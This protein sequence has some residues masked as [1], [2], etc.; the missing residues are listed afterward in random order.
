MRKLLLKWLD[1]L[2]KHLENKPDKTDYTKLMDEI[3]RE[4]TIVDK[5]PNG[6]DR[7]EK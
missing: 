5:L 1:R 3:S 4:I 2:L 7:T 6:Y